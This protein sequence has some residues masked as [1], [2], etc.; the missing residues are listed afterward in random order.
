MRAIEG[1][2]GVG[3]NHQATSLKV[4][5]LPAQPQQL[6][7]AHAQ[8]HGKDVESFERVAVCGFQETVNL[9]AGERL[10]VLRVAMWGIDG[11]KRVGD[12]VTTLGSTVERRLERHVD[13]MSGGPADPACE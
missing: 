5:V 8:G 12:A 13:V 2:R 7:F 4:H 3:G 11:G 10:D 6:A 9:C 1:P